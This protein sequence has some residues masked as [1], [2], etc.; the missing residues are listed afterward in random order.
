MSAPVARLRAAVLGHPIAH[1]RSPLLH[2]TAYRTLGVDIEYTAIDLLPGEAASFAA[3]LRTEPGWVGVSV[4][5]PL[6]DALIPH[7]DELSAR[8]LRLGALNTVV[9]KHL[10]G[11]V[12]LLGYNTDVDGIVRA[13]SNLLPSSLD[14]VHSTGASDPGRVHRAGILGSGN[15]ALAA[16]EACKLLGFTHVD[17]L[18]RNPQ[19]A[20]TALVLAGT[21]GLACRTVE[22]GAAR[23]QVPGYAAVISTLPA[24]AADGLLAALGLDPDAGSAR[25][26]LAP[27]AVLL[28]V[29][30]DPWPSALATAWELA[31]GVVVSGLAML[32]HQ[33]VEQVKLFSGVHNADWRHVTNVMCDAVGLPRP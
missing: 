24:H 28:D 17:L 12:R 1:S 5:M 9:V 23:E 16:L 26:V 13:F 18:V 21:L 25:A 10:D 3:R 32:V 7:L 6:K 14:P 19:R 11:A 27:G 15:T 29:A 33:G 4:T 30:Y 2:A 31:G 20:G 22:I 8:V